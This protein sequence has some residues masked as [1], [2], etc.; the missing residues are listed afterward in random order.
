MIGKLWLETFL[1]EVQWNEYDLRV[2][3]AQSGLIFTKKP[4]AGEPASI[5]GEA[6]PAI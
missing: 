4:I 1:R 6:V 5:G 3:G 2:M